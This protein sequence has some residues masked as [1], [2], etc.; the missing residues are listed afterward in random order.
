MFEIRNDWNTGEQKN[1]EYIKPVSWKYGSRIQVVPTETNLMDPYLDSFQSSEHRRIKGMASQ[2]LEVVEGDADLLVNLD[3]ILY[4]W[5]VC[6]LEALLMARLGF[7]C[8]AKGQPLV[9][10]AK[11]APSVLW[12][13]IV[14]AKSL[15]QYIESSVRFGVN[16]GISLGEAQIAVRRARHMSRRHE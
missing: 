10:E 12:N 8:D 7:A 4:P 14:F 15:S 6:A 5:S 11:R 16:H 1:A 13:G 9:Y 3:P 2:A